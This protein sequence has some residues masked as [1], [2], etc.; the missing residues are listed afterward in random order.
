MTNV[1]TLSPCSSKVMAIL[2]AYYQKASVI[3]SRSQVN[4]IYFGIFVKIF[5]QGIQMRRVKTLSPVAQKLWP[6]L[7]HI[8][9]TVKPV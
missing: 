9:I 5:T 3:K 4:V 6:S 7:K 1:Q 8:T 2:K